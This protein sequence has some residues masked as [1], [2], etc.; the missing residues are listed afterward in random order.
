MLKADDVNLN[1]RS[2]LISLAF[3]GTHI[4]V[5]LA[6]VLISAFVQ[7]IFVTIFCL[8]LSGLLNNSL[9]NLMHEACHRL[10][11]KQ[12]RWSSILGSYGL[13]PYFL[14][15]FELYR[16]R[17]WVHHTHVGEDEDT[18]TTYRHGFA[19]FG[20]FLIFCARAFAGIEAV[21][22]FMNVQKK[23]PHVEP[24]SR[25]EV[26]AG[27]AKLVLFHAVFSCTILFVALLGSSF[28]IQAAF[29]WALASYAVVYVYGMM[30]VTIIMST[31]R[32]MAEH[33][34]LAD[35]DYVRGQATLRNLK[36]TPSTRIL[37]GSY[38]F[39]EHATHHIAPNIPAYN[40]P[41]VTAEMSKKKKH[42]SYTDSY[43]TVIA[44]IVAG[45]QA[46]SR[47]VDHAR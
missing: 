30:S 22:R 34:V 5:V 10:V 28:Q 46:A 8:F 35:D 15:N 3:S 12:P 42:L 29:V 27:L 9:A 16:R 44:K 7:N 26:Y 23:N 17:H 47:A 6:P 13:A 11:F 1:R 37:F 32:A 14:I 36:P 21:R 25:E 45:K 33:F 31:V 38:G 39:C 40:L 18:K 20:D 41:Y 2:D 24:L 43:W 19:G 4:I